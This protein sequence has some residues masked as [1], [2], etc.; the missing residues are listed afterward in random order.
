[1]SVFCIK[2][3]WEVLSGTAKPAAKKRPAAPGRHGPRRN[4]K[5]PAPQARYR[6]RRINLRQA[7]LRLRL[8]LPVR[9]GGAG[10]EV[11]RVQRLRHLLV[12]GE[13]LL[14]A[15]LRLL[16]E[17]RPLLGLRGLHLLEAV[18]LRQEVVE[19]PLRRRRVHLERALAE[20]D[21]A[22]VVAEERPV[23]GLDRLLLLA[24]RVGEVVAVGDAVAVRD[25]HG[26]A[27][28]AVGLLE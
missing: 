14:H 19:E 10:D 6:A 18:L 3:S 4:A 1:M 2:A 21:L 24:E 8:R 23:P 22:R 9:R 27:V 12:Q 20:R 5:G 7:E 11:L 25:D 17:L 16:E 26:D 15:A 13:A 28:V